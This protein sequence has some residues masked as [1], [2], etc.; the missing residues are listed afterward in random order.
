MQSDPVNPAP[1]GRSRRRLIALALGALLVVGA[2][3]AAV[4]LVERPPWLHDVKTALQQVP[5]IGQLPGIVAAP[6]G[7]PTLPPVT[8]GSTPPPLTPGAT[9]N[10]SFAGS[11]DTIPLENRPEF[12]YEG[13]Q[14]WQIQGR[15]EP[16]RLI[17]GYASAPSYFPRDGEVDSVY[18]SAEWWGPLGGVYD[19]PFAVAANL[20]GLVPYLRW[21]AE[22]VW[23]ELPSGGRV[24]ASGTFYWGWALDPAFAASHDVPA[25]FGRLTLNILAWLAKGR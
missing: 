25:G 17:E 21:T 6:T 15:S 10:P 7:L 12:A 1:G 3:A 5:V 19:H 4:V 11:A 20:A 16:G 18:P 8:L 23:R 13:T 22:A 24:F 2:I 14:P 9:R